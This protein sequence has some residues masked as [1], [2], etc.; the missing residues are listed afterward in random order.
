[1]MAEG[2]GQMGRCR[3]QDAL[4]RFGAEIEAKH[5][6]PQEL[7]KSVHCQGGPRAVSRGFAPEEIIDPEAETPDGRRLAD[8][9][10]SFLQHDGDGTDVID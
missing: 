4:Q 8:G 7:W 9:Q 3:Q 2:N 1:M 5:N 6:S 10:K